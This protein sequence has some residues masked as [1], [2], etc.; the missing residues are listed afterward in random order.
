MGKIKNMERLH[1]LIFGAALCVCLIFCPLANA[2]SYRPQ[3]GIRGG[4]T[5]SP[6]DW[7]GNLKVFP[8]IGMSVDFRIAKLPFYI[9]TGAYY[10]NRYVYEDDNNSLLFPA[11]LSYHIPLKHDMTLQPFCGP[12]VS[13][14]FDNSEVDGGMRMGIGFSKSRFY[15]NC[16]Y[17]ISFNYGYDEDNFFV[18]AGYNF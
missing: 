17:D 2:Q 1:K 12:F 11:L 4:L 14:G 8:T 15:V 16:G 10:L 13:Y 6:T 18:T 5:A 3:F 7:T 9:E